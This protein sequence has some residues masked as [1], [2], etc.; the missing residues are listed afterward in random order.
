[1]DIHSLDPLENFF[2]DIAFPVGKGQLV[3]E[4]QDWPLPQH[5]RDALLLLPE[6][7]YL[8][9]EEVKSALLGQPFD[10]GIP[11]KHMEEIKDEDDDMM[12]ELVDL[13]EFTQ[14]GD[15]EDH[16]SV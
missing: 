13:D 14:M 12:D 8:T 11:K 10:D 4:A 7:L 6:H 15:E 2:D 3:A 1:M 16:E 5:V 9:R